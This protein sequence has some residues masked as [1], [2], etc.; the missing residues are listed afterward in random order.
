[1]NIKFLILIDCFYH[2]KNIYY[3]KKHNFFT[4][5]LVTNSLNPLLV[6]FFIPILINN[7]FIHFFFIKFYL[8]TY[9]SVL[10]DKYNFY[11]NL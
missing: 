2:F 10:F 8:L 3:F 7:F 9:K 11:K 4:L 6:D 1:M 5:G